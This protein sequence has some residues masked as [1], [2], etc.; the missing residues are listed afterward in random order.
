MRA[1]RSLRP[2]SRARRAAPARARRRARARRW[3]SP[4]ARAR[5]GTA[6]PSTRGVEMHVG[7]LRERAL[8]VA[9]D[10]DQLRALALQVRRQQ[11]AARRSR[12]NST[13]SRTTSSAVIMPRSP[14]PASAGCTKNAGVPVDASVAASLRATW[15]DLPMPDT[16]TRP[17]H[18][19]ISSTAA[20]NGAP[21]RC[22]ERA[23][24]S[25]SVASTSAGER[26]A[27]APR[28]R[29]RGRGRAWRA[30]QARLR[31]HA[32]PV[33]RRLPSAAVLHDGGIARAT[34]WR[35]AHRRGCH[36]PTPMPQTLQLILVL[37]A[38]RSSWS[39]SAGSRGCR[40]SSATCSSA[41]RVGP[42]ALGVGARRRATPLPRRV[43]HRVPDVLDRARVQPA[44]AARDAPR[45]VR[46][47]ARAGRRSRRS[48]AMVVLRAPRATAGRPASRSAARSR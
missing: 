37:L 32:S 9:G 4:W 11:R 43:R 23:I 19:E 35:G 13:A 48:A 22:C 29:A 31:G 28:R 41:S 6:S 34:G 16:T 25:A 15:P 10:R 2:R 7:R 18:R 30:A 26:A 5:A 42:H 45:G 12:R 33:Y 24:A 27:R 21:S 1:R 38:A 40:R 17:R 14:W 20:T 8:L 47:R 46:P 3:C 39:S 36:S 44:A